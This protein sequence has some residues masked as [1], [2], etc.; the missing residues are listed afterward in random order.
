MTDTKQHNP[1]LIVSTDVRDMGKPGVIVELT[2]ERAAIEG[3]FEEDAVDFDTAAAAAFGD[4]QE[5]DDD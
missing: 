2:K 3:I 5:R 1:K 4:D